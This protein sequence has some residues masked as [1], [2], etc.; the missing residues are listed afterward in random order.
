MPVSGSSGMVSSKLRKI[1]TCSFVEMTS[2]TDAELSRFCPPNIVDIGAL[3]VSGAILCRPPPCVDS[4]KTDV[5]QMLRLLSWDTR[6][7]GK[8]TD[9][10]SVV[11]TP[12]QADQRVEV[13]TSHACFC[14]DAI[15]SARQWFAR[16]VRGRSRGGGRGM[17]PDLRAAMPQVNPMGQRIGKPARL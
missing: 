8:P 5:R 15:C 17:G 14:R 7:R 4:M 11:G 12:E 16:D 13:T 9:G 10:S 1:S 6:S 2:S 3:W